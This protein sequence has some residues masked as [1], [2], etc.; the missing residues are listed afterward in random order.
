MTSCAELED[1]ENEEEEKQED[2]PKGDD[3]TLIILKALPARMGWRQ[4]FHLLEEMRQG[5]A[6]AFQ[7][8]E[9]Y[10]NKAGNIV[11]SSKGLAQYATC[12]MAIT[13]TDDDLLLGSK[14]HNHPL[15]VIGYIREQKVKRILVDGG[16]AINIMPLSTVNGL[17]ITIEELSKSG[18]MIQGFSLE[19]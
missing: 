14:P 18:M 15:Y 13:F 8:A 7:H 10:V 17:G 11:E 2:S 16:S 6:A 19:N 12:N 4:I 1:E 5:V 3:K 9:L